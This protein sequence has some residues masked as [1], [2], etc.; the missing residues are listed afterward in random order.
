MTKYLVK[1]VPLDTFFFSQEN[2]YRKKL[3]KDGAGKQVMS[4]EAEYFQKSTY[5]PQ[6]TALLGMLR[7]YILQRNNQIPITDV[8]KAIK[9]I[10]NH[11]FDAGIKSNNFEKI[12]NLSAVFIIDDKND[13]FFKNPKDLIIK[14]SNTVYLNKTDAI[15][16]TTLTDNMLF[17]DNYVEK[18]GL[19]NFLI[20]NEDNI[21]PFDFD[22]DK[23]P[24]G[25]FIKKERVGITKQ[26]KGKT[27]ENAF[28]KQTFYSLRKGFSFG[29]VA[30]IEDMEKHSGFVYLGAEKSA[31]TI[32]FEKFQGNIEDKINLN[33]VNQ[34]KIVLLSD[35]YISDYKTDDFQFAV[36]STKT[37][38]FLK[39]E[40]KEGHKYYSSNPLNNRD[41]LK[42]KGIRRSVKY[43]LL[44]RGSVF[45]FKDQRQMDGFT[46]KIENE[47]N[48]YQIG[49][50]QYIKLN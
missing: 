19:S 4:T 1:L 26:R 17:F 7:Y 34:P 47:S 27:K 3:K 35:A 33:R 22:R 25:V 8:E 49:Y 10:G 13:F 41:P 46:K 21:L 14:N 36:S 18:E 16:K 31:F 42:K 37:F 45:Y 32:S 20:H 29:F 40:V 50:N 39:T 28:Y 23:V 6:Q 9:L 38:R 43:N 2:K 44:E 48:F 11:S 30:E 12:K 24:N 15:F 5:F